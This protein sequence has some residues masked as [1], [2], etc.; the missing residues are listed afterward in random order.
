MSSL[1]ESRWWD[2]ALEGGLPDCRL[3]LGRE[4]GVVVRGTPFGEQRMEKVYCANCGKPEGL[5]TAGWCPHVFV[6][7]QP[8]AK[9]N[10]P[11][12]GLVEVPEAVARGRARA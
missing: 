7:C 2:K 5:V 8:C 4:S 3:T 6:L 9:K 10:G 12:P 11:P 1:R